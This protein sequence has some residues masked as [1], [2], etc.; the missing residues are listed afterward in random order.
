MA[1]AEPLPDAVL[2]VLPDAAEFVMLVLPDVALPFSVE[3]ELPPQAVSETAITPAR[4]ALNS[5]LFFI[6]RTS[7][8]LHH[9]KAT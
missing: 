6:F 2:A 1:A 4:R 3:V 5:F 9:V 8:Y 7:S